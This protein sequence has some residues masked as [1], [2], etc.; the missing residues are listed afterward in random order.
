MRRCTLPNASSTGLRRF[1]G[2]RRAWRSA[3]WRFAPRGE[4][5][6][7]GEPE[8]KFAPPAVN[9]AAMSS[10]PRPAKKSQCL[11]TRRDDRDHRHEMADDEPLRSG[12]ADV[13]FQSRARTAR[14]TWRMTRFKT[15]PAAARGLYAEHRAMHRRVWRRGGARVVRRG[16]GVVTVLGHKV[17]RRRLQRASERTA[18]RPPKPSWRR[19]GERSRHGRRLRPP[20]RLVHAAHPL[21]ARQQRAVVRPRSRGRSPS[22]ARRLALLGEAACRPGVRDGAAWG[23]GGCAR[24]STTTSRASRR[25]PQRVRLA[26]QPAGYPSLRLARR[27][28]RLPSRSRRRGRRRGRENC[29]R[30]R[31]HPATATRYEWPITAFTARRRC[32][33]DVRRRDGQGGGRRVPR[34][35]RRARPRVA[36]ALMC[37][38][39]W[40]LYEPSTPM[41]DRRASARRHQVCKAC[42][43]AALDAGLH[44]V[45]SNVWLS[46]TSSLFFTVTD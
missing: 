14:P 30:A 10:R 6:A 23:I 20:P 27:R 43:K 39:P 7:R 25:L 12:R 21:P 46:T 31:A 34:R 42:V 40:D 32:S 19:A 24:L 45:R 28:D 36:L 44:T 8:E 29:A 3:A 11:L 38:S 16:A 15:T 33:E 41:W 22:T 37:L 35:R 9:S 1:G 5:L 4:V 17:A 13:D 26:A 2:R 18:R